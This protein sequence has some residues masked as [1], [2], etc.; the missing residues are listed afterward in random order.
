MILF[1][2][3]DKVKEIWSVFLLHGATTPVVDTHASWRQAL[4]QICCL[5]TTVVPK[6]AD[7]TEFEANL[8]V[9]T[10]LSCQLQHS[11]RRWAFDAG[12]VTAHSLRRHR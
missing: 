5:T 1:A 3:G 11:S 8:T 4:E 12:T 7:P 10:E 6:E 9:E 2:G